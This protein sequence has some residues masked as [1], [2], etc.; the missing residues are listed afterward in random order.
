[1]DVEIERSPDDYDSHF[2]FWKP[3]T[4]P[5][6]EPDGLAWQLDPG[7]DLV[8]NA[9]LKPTGKPAEVAPS[10]GLYFTDKPPTQF[11]IVMEL[12]DDPALNIPPGD[13]D[14][15]VRDDFRLPADVDVLAIYPHAHY[16]GRSA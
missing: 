5:W 15:I 6:V 11:P 1:M 13:P 14:F 2:L 9:H 10:I 3:G 4:K 16:L 12:E 8:L 7:E